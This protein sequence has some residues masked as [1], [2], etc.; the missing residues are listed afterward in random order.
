MKFE[1]LYSELKQ[2]FLSAN[3]ITTIHPILDKIKWPNNSGVYVVWQRVDTG[4]SLIY[5]G[6]TG[7]FKRKGSSVVLGN[8]LFKGRV[9]RWTP[10][11]F[12]ESYKDS[13]YK[14]HFRFGP[15]EKA[16]SKQGLIRFDDHAYRCSIPYTELVIDCFHVDEN[17]AE[18]TPAYLEAKLLTVYLKEYGDLP[19]ANN[20]L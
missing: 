14:Y 11:R 12:C 2:N 15:V 17:H 20:T 16:V 4:L 8:S 9:T 13:R 3:S 10:Y 5:V 6:L 1:K 7:K 18:Y 19:P